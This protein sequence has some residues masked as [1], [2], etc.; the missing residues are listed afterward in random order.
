[1]AARNNAREASRRLPEG[2]RRTR[3]RITRRKMLAA[4][5][6]QLRERSIR[7]IKVVTI[8]EAAGV[9]PAAFYQYFT[10]LDDAMLALA[11]EMVADA[12][13]LTDLM[14]GDWQRNGTE[15][16]T[17][18]V[19]GFLA[20]WQ[21][22]EPV[23]RVIELAIDEH[24]TQFNRVRTAMLNEA[25][26]ALSFVIANFKEAGLQPPD[27]QPRA[28]AAALI[29]VLIHVS[30]RLWLYEAWGLETDDIKNA[31]SDIL[32]TMVTRQGVAGAQ[33]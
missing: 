8:A 29:A 30:A 13:Q 32:H 33:V 31:V 17:R 12:R 5:E 22:H 23:L 15:L 10:G 20:F 9:T 21:R 14:T 19:D 11:D 4:L 1:V 2:E 3:G 25:T 27:V 28:L 24:D 16:T 26:L 18:L 6:D 7:D